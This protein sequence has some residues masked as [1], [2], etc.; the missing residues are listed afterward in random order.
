MPRDTVDE[1]APLDLATLLPKARR[2]DRQLARMLPYVSLVDDVTVRARGGELFQCV[3]LDGLNAGTA[4]DELLD[5]AKGLFAQLVAQ[6]GPGYAFYVHKVSKAVR[7][8]LLPIEGDG[9]AA[10]LDARWRAHLDGLGLRDKTL[11]LTVMKRPDLGS[12]VPL[13]AR[14]S[15]EKLRSETA[16]ALRRLNEV[17]GF[18]LSSFGPMRP[19]RLAASTG[20]L[21][22]F[23]GGLNT[24]E[25]LP[26]H[27]ASR[28]GFVAEDVANTRVAFRGARFMLS[29]GVVGRKYG[30]T[31]AI[32]TYPAKTTV[33]MFD[34]I[35]PVRWTV[36]GL[37]SY[38][39]G[40]AAS[41]L[42]S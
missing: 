19:R 24:G 41:L 27:P 35:D 14:K 26:L 7:H 2:S 40:T 10:S 12:K 8:D 29:E 15:A 38:V 32:K 4:E 39:S 23:L 42:A 34:G 28:F 13:L 3:R 30:T 22:G 21:L 31:F 25:E 9:F 1:G 37:G 17:V 33:G 11:T 5:R 16:L 6:V 20:E 36:C 18:I